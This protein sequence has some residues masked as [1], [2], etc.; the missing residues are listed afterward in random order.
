[1]SGRAHLYPGY[2]TGVYEHLLVFVCNLTFILKF[3]YGNSNGNFHLRVS[4][5]YL[6]TNCINR[7]R[8]MQ[9]PLKIFPFSLIYILRAFRCY[10]K[11]T[12]LTSKLNLETISP[13]GMPN[14][15]SRRRQV[16]GKGADRRKRVYFWTAYLRR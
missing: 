7:Y 5:T 10:R 12:A 15:P 8:Y 16:Y 13:L 6:G 14:K 4:A 1:M 11:R 3:S 9:I 2:S